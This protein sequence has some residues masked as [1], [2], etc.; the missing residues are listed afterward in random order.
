MTDSVSLPSLAKSRRP[1]RSLPSTLSLLSHLPTRGS[2]FAS[3]KDSAEP[4]KTN[5]ESTIS[6]QI[7]MYVLRIQQDSHVPL[8]THVR[9]RFFFVNR[10]PFLSGSGGSNT[11]HL[12]M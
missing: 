8:A 3:W 1:T 2:A 10:L 5:A 6:D 12:P 11:S 7:R 9:L 4:A